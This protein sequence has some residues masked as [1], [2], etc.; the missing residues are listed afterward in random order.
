MPL[1]ARKRGFR[2]PAAGWPVLLSGVDCPVKTTTDYTRRYPRGGSFGRGFDSRHLHL[3]HR[4]TFNVNRFPWNGVLL[5]HPERTQ[6][7]HAVCRRGDIFEHSQDHSLCI[8][9]KCGAEDSIILPAHELLT[10]PNTILLA[11][12]V[13]YIR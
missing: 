8:Y 11:N 2:A 4:S 6:D 10:S 12:L 7:F 1:T 9:Q 5:I 3:K 13:L